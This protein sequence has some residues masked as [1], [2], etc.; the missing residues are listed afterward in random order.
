VFGLF[1]ALMRLLHERHEEVMVMRNG[2]SETNISEERFRRLLDRN[3]DSVYRLAYTYLH[4]K[5]DADD[6]FQEVFLRYLS[7]RPAF[8][9]GIHERA[10]FIRVTINVCH[11]HHRSIWFRKRVSLDSFAGAADAFGD[12]AEDDGQGAELLHAVMRLSDKLRPTVHL[13]YYEGYSVREISGIL[14]VNEST[15]R[16]RLMQARS[17]LKDLLVE[18]ECCST[19]AARVGKEGF[20]L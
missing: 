5:A 8:S 17:K 2:T 14:G 19:G 1:V 18:E 6:A 20:V 13:F 12:A 4:S 10:W 7:N 9:D 11:S 15:I 3:K 16:S